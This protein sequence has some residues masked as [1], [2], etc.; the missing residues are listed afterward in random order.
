MLQH[1][2]KRVCD[3][4]SY[5]VVVCNE[6]LHFLGFTSSGSNV[7]SEGKGRFLLSFCACGK[8]Q[9]LLSFRMSI[10][11]LLVENYQHKF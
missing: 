1:F 7:K 4:F 9:H 5:T 10:I 6:A 8:S 3:Q 2:L 11:I